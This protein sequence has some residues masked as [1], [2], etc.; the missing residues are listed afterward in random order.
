VG[1]STELFT[2]EQEVEFEG[3][4]NQAADIVVTS[5]APFPHAIRTLAFKSNAF[6]DG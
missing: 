1:S 5:A 3:G 4:H 2:G 6:G